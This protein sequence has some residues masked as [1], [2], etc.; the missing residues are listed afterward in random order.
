MGRGAPLRSQIPHESADS[1]IERIILV[2]GHHVRGARDLKVL[3]LW[4]QLPQLRN[5]L[6]MDDLTAGPTD[7]QDGYSY[8]AHRC[9]HACEHSLVGS[10]F[11]TSMKGRIPMPI[12][13][14]IGT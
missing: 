8:I 2:A 1:T 6:V 11:R 4:D 5:A 10:V 9:G 14:A 3:C 7:D 13:A 12:P